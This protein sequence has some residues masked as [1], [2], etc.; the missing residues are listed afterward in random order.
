MAKFDFRILLETVEGK[1]TSYI[2]QSFVDTSVDLVLSASQ[3]YGRITGSVSCSYQ[4]AQIFSGSD[5]NTNFTFKDNNLLSASLS[6]S[7]DTGSIDFDATT[8]E[9]DR[10]LR[11]KFFGEKV[12]NVLGLP[13]NQWVYVDQ[14]RFP[15]DEES[16]I[17]QGNIDVSTAFI[18]D[19]LTFANNANINSDVQFFIDTGSDRY[20]KFIDTRGSGNSSLIFGYDKENDAYEINASE[21]TTFNISNVNSLTAG[22]ITASIYHQELTVGETQLNTLLAGVTTVSGSI[23]D[24]PLMRIQGNLSSSGEL[25]SSTLLVTGTSQFSGDITVG[26]S[27][28]AEEFITK[29]ITVQ[30]GSNVFGNSDDDIHRFTGSLDIVHTG[31]DVGLSLSGSDLRVDGDISASGDISTTSNIVSSLT[32]QGEHL[33]STD[34]LEIRGNLATVGNDVNG[35]K[36]F[37]PSSLEG[38]KDG[39]DLIISGG[40]AFSPTQD[41]DGGDVKIVGGT[42]R[43]DGTD[44]N[45]ILNPHQ[46][47]VGVGTNSPLEKLHVEGNITSS[48]TISGSKI[49]A[50]T[51]DAAAVT[52]TL[53]ATIVDEIDDGEISISKLTETAVTITAGDGLTGAGT[54]TLGETKTINVIAGDGI[55]VNPDN[56]A[57]DS[58]QTTISSLLNTGLVI[59]ADAN[60]QINFGTTNNIIFEV[61][62]NNELQ[63]DASTL[64]PVTNDGLAL[65][66]GTKAWSDLF[67]AQGA[68]INFDNGDIT[69][70]DNDTSLDIAGDDFTGINISGHITA[71]SGTISASKF[72]GDG[73]GITGVT[74]EWDGTI[75]GDARVT[76]SLFVTSDIN[77]EGNIV[78]DGSTNIINLNSITDTAGTT[79][80]NFAST[81]QLSFTVGGETILKLIEN[82]VQ[83][84][85]EVGDGGDVDFLVKGLNDDS[86]LHIV[87]SSDFVGIG[88][89]NPTKKLQVTGDISASGDLFLGGKIEIDGDGGF[90]D[91]TI[92]VSGDR[93]RLTDKSS[94]DVIVDAG[95]SNA[96]GDFRVR[97]H[98]GESTRFIVSSS[99]NVGIGVTSPTKKLQVEGD[100]SASGYLST[101]SHITASGNISSSANIKANQIQAFSGGIISNGASIFGNAS[102]DTH[103]FTGNVTASGNISAS[104]K[105]NVNQIEFT[106]PNSKDSNNILFDLSSSVIP[107]GGFVSSSK[108]AGL[109]WEFTNDDFFIYAHQSASDKTKMVFES[110]D[111]LTDEFVFWFNAPGGAATSASNSFPLAMTGERFVVNHIYD[112]ATTYH[113]D[114]NG[115]GNLPANNVDFYLLKSGSTTVSKNNSLIFGDVSDSQVTIN[116]DITASGNISGSGE[117]RINQIYVDDGAEAT[118]SIAFGLAGQEDTGIYRRSN[119]VIGFSAGGDGQ[120]TLNESGVSIGE[121][122]V[123]NDNKP[124]TANSLIVEGSVGINETTPVE[125]L[126]VIGNV[127]IEDAGTTNYIE[128]TEGDN[129]RARILIDNSTTP[130]AFKIQTH[131]NSS[132]Y[133]DRIVVKHQQSA[134]QVG[135][136]TVNPTKELQVT[137]DIS[138]SGNIH[139]KNNKGLLIGR[140]SDG[141]QQSVIKVD[142][143]DNVTIGSNN[144]DDMILVTDNGEAVRIKGNGSVGIGTD[145]PDYSLDVA[146]NVGIDEHIYHNGDGDTFF[147]FNGDDNIQL[148][149]GGSHL[150]FTPTG[151]GVGVTATEKLD[152]NGNIKARRNISSPSFFSGFAGS[153]FSIESG[154]DGKTTFTIDDLTVRNSARV[155]ELLIHQVRA[156]NGSLF[157]S[158]TGKVLSASLSDVANHFTMSFDTG[159]GYGHSFVKG[160][161][162]RAQRFVP[163]T[164]GSGSELFKSDLHVISTDNTGSIIAVLSGSGNSL[165]TPQPGY[166]YVRIGNLH[167]A[168]S[169]RQGSIYLTSDDNNAPFIDVIDQVT[170]HSHFNTSE[171]V[172]TRIGKLDGITTSTRFGTLSG[173]GF[174]ASGSAFLE[175][176][177]NAT[178]GSIGAFIIDNTEIK[179]R[180]GDAD[181]RLKSSGQITG[182]NVLFDGGKVGGF[183]IGSNIISSSNGT[184]ILN[185]DGTITGSAVSMSGTITA[186]SGKIAGWDIDGNILKN[187]TDIQLDGGNKKI[188]INDPDFG[189]TG[190]QL[191]FNSGAPRAHIG[192]KGSSGIRFEELGGSTSTLQI[193][194]SNVDMSGSDVSILTPSVFLG[195]GN[196]NFISASG[197][198]LEIS[199]SNFHLKG[200]NITASNVQLSGS[201]KADSGDIGG[202]TISD[203]E[204]SASDLLLKSSGQITASK[205]LIN[206][207][208]KIAGFTI[209]NNEI[210]SGNFFKLN[211]TDKTLQLG[212]V[213]DF[214]KDSSDKGMFVDGDDGQVFIGKEDGEFI[215]FDGTNLNLSSSNLNITASDIDMTTDSF[216][217]SATNLEISSTHASMSLGDGKILL[218]GSSNPFIDIGTGSR[219]VR[220]FAGTTNNFIRVASGSNP[221]TGLGHYNDTSKTGLIFGT[222]SG[223]TRFGMTNDSNNHFQFDDNG[224][225]IKATNATLSGSSVEILTP[226]FFLGS[227]TNNISSSNDDLSITTKNLTASGSN[228]EILSPNVFLGAGNTNFISA[229]SGKIEISSSNFHLKEGNITASSVDLSGKIKATSGEFSGSITAS[230]GNVGG[231]NISTK[232]ES[233]NQ[234]IILDPIGNEIAVGTGTDDNIIKIDS[235]DGLFAGANTGGT[236]A[237]ST[238]FQVSPT[239][240]MTASSARIIGDSFVSCSSTSTGSFGR[241]G[242]SVQHTTLGSGSIELNT[243]TSDTTMYEAINTIDN[244]L[245]KLAPAKPPNL[246]DSFMSLDF[247]TSITTFTG[248]GTNGAQTESIT[249]NTSPT[250]TVYSGSVENAFFFDGDNGELTA[251]RAVNDGA[252][253]NIGTA[254]ITTGDDK[255]TYQNTLLITGDDDFHEGTAGSEGFWRALKAQVKETGRTAG[256][257]RY[258]VKLKHSITG[259]VTK[260]YYVDDSSGNQSILTNSDVSYISESNGEHHQSGIPYLGFGDIVSASYDVQ[261]NS[262]A[263]FVNSNG[264]IGGAR[265]LASNGSTAITSLA[266]NNVAN[267]TW[268]SGSSFNI[269]QS[270][271]ILNSKFHTGANDIQFVEFKSTTTALQ[272]AGQDVNKNLNIDSLTEDETNPTSGVERSGSG[273]GRFPSF[274]FNDK[275]ASATTFGSSFNTTASL[276]TSGHFE[277]QYSNEFYH[278]PASIDYSNYI[279]SGPDYTSMNSDSSPVT[280]LRWVTFKVGTI[281]LERNVTLR[282][283]DCTGFD[284][285][286]IQTSDGFEMYLK[287]MNGSTEVTKWINC[288]LGYNSGN[289][290]QF[291]DNDGGLVEDES[292]GASSGDLDRKITFGS[293]NTSGEVYVRAGW[294]VSGG[295][296]PT[297]SSTRKFN[298]ISIV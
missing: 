251:S 289:P 190:I 78:G 63:L 180:E 178:S 156:T 65:G 227:A 97:A 112:R 43:N 26:G 261:I 51:L 290:G 273:T 86:L 124:S 19:T 66:T 256:T 176:S 244:I 82:D 57:V 85:I 179:D 135:I 235:N 147:K 140:V 30:N 39:G 126:H 276:K 54:Y 210:K 203:T 29:Q 162:I 165:E 231:F 45:V 15:V 144:L 247:N 197:G 219:A 185:N 113:R 117:L 53:A 93:L 59:G 161:L 272:D 76:G 13:N 196:S 175:G 58:S 48:G 285:E 181:L 12:C 298:H 268:N 18:S 192:L 269:T 230:S 164:N 167:A 137:G 282:L 80:I 5:F 89:S 275:V 159:S 187:G 265:I 143:D 109:Q 24:E 281:S 87:G 49:Y 149:A 278:W 254:S 33:R 182:S 20:I 153:G 35:F 280:G 240:R 21:N 83:D 100:I 246:S 92:E 145:S 32:I 134:T 266:T 217:L 243:F 277:L 123:G 218:S 25:T 241:L 209:N 95:G 255:D 61:Q 17:F 91:A 237:D 122:Y 293:L 236:R 90:S 174:Y 50:H 2:S 105:L 199:S 10:L 38:N 34:D 146:G 71:S 128:F 206:G 99:G 258:F 120:M 47:K 274:A 62:G 107:S 119:N 188:S 106:K 250:F 288:N 173:Y 84:R 118:P 157:V 102:N 242:G 52:D 103:K 40:N 262:N 72:I 222:I 211:S 184:L 171:K 169:S 104:G 232:L 215:H 194:S 252:F 94:V 198:K 16:N 228:V 115:V 70:T 253:T 64:F 151:L 297:G 183:E 27:V 226:N 31:S 114:G 141:V 150:N 88:T 158:N 74:A 220:L 132:A 260:S 155:F 263:N 287:V 271:S 195:Q 136:G 216:E 264:T 201:I 75:D 170:S 248:R 172:K 212:T 110:R 207:E 22:T 101:E 189:D 8:S 127:R 129:E 6:G 200:G 259:E 296:H 193:T 42:K 186:T 3:V 177:I 69:L 270:L 166:E 7:L 279:P 257:D 14:V 208:S 116:G 267:Q 292:T 77:A 37:I 214:N 96:P 283:Q 28:T 225:Q 160:D 139:L 79:G 168:S 286:V 130:G 205:A 133:Q 229:S 11:Y 223:K 224:I 294:N 249:T 131:D 81:D 1:K 60:N 295:T 108:V 121:G 46:G 245:N 55:V 36:I 111:N 191:E 202:F 73:A 44:G 142:T 233:S 98:S 148:S 56:V 204:I 41:R 67:L 125:K 284:S 213:E 138:A 154:S 9:Y 291:N 152:V 221:K 4:N 68:I 238:P 163:S 23:S 239:G 234:N